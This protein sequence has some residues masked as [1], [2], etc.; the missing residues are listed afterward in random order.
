MYKKTPRSLLLPIYFATLMHTS[1][2]SKSYINYKVHCLPNILFLPR[3]PLCGLNWITPD[4]CCAAAVVLTM[5]YLGYRCE[6]GYS[7]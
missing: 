3:D 7:R 4:H 2:D 6:K 5:Y 1:S